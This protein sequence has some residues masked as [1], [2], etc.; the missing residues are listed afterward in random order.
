MS[1]HG[2]AGLGV[3]DAAR[4]MVEPTP[5]ILLGKPNSF[6]DRYDAVPVT[7]G[8]RLELPLDL[9]EELKRKLLQ[10]P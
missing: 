1:S 3:R 5:Q 10:R 4:R 2:Q 7:A 6:V 8:I 9:P